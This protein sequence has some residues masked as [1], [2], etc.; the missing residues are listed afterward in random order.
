MKNQKGFTLIEIMVV[1]II[2]GLLAGLVLPR[3]MGQEDKAR[4]ETAKVQIRSLEGALDAFKLD[5][6]FYPASDQ[7]LDALIRKPESG[8]IPTRW[9]EGGYLKPARIPKDPWNKEF[10]Y[11]S[12]GSEG[13]EYEIV[14]YGADNEPGGEGNNTDI[15]SWKMQ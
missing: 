4:I 10:V 5:N 6:G 7:G 2:L 15:E 13:R 12:P 14:S 8:R 11:L 3:I 1:V 9:R